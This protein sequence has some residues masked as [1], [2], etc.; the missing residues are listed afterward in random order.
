[1]LHHGSTLKSM[2]N[3]RR[4]TQKDTDVSAYIMSTEVK[5]NRDRKCFSGNVGEAGKEIMG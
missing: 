1:M 2:L 5:S 4:Q 3:K